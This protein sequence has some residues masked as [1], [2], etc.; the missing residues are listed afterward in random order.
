M[1]DDTAYE[2]TKTFWEQK[3]ELAEISRWW[4]GV[5]PELMENVSTAFHPGALRYY[6]EAGITVP[7]AS[8]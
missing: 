2:L 6:E 5:T 8:N 4:N 7:G 3:A 1:D